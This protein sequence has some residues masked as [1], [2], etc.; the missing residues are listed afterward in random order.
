[1]PCRGAGGAPRLLPLPQALT[2][3]FHAAF[4]PFEYDGD[5]SKGTVLS[6]TAHFPK[7]LGKW[8][9]FPQVRSRYAFAIH[10][11]RFCHSCILCVSQVHV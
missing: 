10:W 6:A 7:V 9:N 4:V 11:C 1:M 3:P 2:D 5:Q 8:T